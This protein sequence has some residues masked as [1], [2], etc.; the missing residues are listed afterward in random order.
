MSEQI[1][2]WQCC[3]PRRGRSWNIKR[4]RRQRCAR[5]CVRSA[6]RCQLLSAFLEVPG[7]P[8][9]F[10]G[11][12]WLGWHLEDWSVMACRALLL[13]S[14]HSHCPSR[15]RRTLP[16][17]F[18]VL[19]SLKIYSLVVTPFSFC[20]FLPVL[21][22]HLC[23]IFTSRP[24]FPVDPLHSLSSPHSL[25]SLLSHIFLHLVTYFLS[26]T[27]CYICYLPPSL[28]LSLSVGSLRWADR[29]EEPACHGSYM[30]RGREKGRRKTSA[31]TRPNP[32]E[33]PHCSPRDRGSDQRS[34]APGGRDAG[35]Q[36]CSRS[37]DFVLI[38]VLC[39]SGVR[40]FSAGSHFC[41]PTKSTEQTQ[42]TTLAEKQRR[43]S[44]RKTALRLSKST[45]VFF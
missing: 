17:F 29:P 12:S 31:P 40:C 45:F 43:E 20:H 38:F 39:W 27:P 22:F 35:W 11:W 2:A 14:S 7:G 28:S 32:P 3:S 25:A 21:I 16:L 44:G 41:Q 23:L 8:A 33:A 9:G 37:I 4:K 34:N 36:P 19:L 6:R 26:P 15:P 13:S 5:V 30:Q 18:P 10:P 24:P 1:Q 42:R